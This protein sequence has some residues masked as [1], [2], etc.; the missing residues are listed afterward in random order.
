VKKD[1]LSKYI[2]GFITN[3]LINMFKKKGG[4]Q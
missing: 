1:L 3:L 4:S 2:F